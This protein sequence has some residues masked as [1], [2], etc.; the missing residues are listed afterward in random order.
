MYKRQPYNID[1]NLLYPTPS[2]V[3]T[4]NNV[5]NAEPL[6]SI[7]LDPKANY[8]FAGS[9]ADS[10]SLFTKA[11]LAVSNV[12]QQNDS[13]FHAQRFDKTL[14]YDDGS[15]ERAYGLE[16]LGLKKFAYEFNL[17]VPDTLVG[18]QIHYTNIDV[19]VEDLV[20]SLIHI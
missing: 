14:S 12:N 16:G 2:V 15:A 18:F 13:L 20:L 9:S 7:L 8:T 1:V 11:S 17:N 10:I 3:F 6:K 19:R 4:T 5:F